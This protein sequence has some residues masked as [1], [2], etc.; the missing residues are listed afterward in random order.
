MFSTF[1]YII[2]VVTAYVMGKKFYLS[3][4]IGIKW[5]NAQMVGM[6]LTSCASWLTVG[7]IIIGQYVKEGPI[8]DWLDTDAKF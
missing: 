8:K 5:N 4:N 3:Q 6:V 7:Y 2:G 1:L